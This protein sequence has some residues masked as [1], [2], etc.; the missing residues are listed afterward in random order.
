MLILL[1][2]SFLLVLLAVIQAVVGILF[3][4]PRPVVAHFFCQ[5][6]F[7][8]IAIVIAVGFAFEHHLTVAWLSLGVFFLFFIYGFR[9]WRKMGTVP[10]SRS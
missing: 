2:T 5:T 3:Y 9:N 7:V 8:F 4:R 1:K 6:L 10:I